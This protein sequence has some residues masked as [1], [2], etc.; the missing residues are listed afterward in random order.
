MRYLKAGIRMGLLFICAL[1]FT[2]A[3]LGQA[4]QLRLN[5][6]LTTTA[7]AWTDR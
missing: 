3:L 6:H 5:P 7:T 1:V 2:T 4:Q